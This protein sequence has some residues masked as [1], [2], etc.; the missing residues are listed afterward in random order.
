MASCD[1]KMHFTLNGSLQ[2]CH[3]GDNDMARRGHPESLNHYKLPSNEN[4]LSSF[5]KKMTLP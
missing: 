1:G 4:V 3:F 2:H 5:C